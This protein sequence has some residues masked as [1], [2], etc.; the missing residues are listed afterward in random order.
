[1]S[2]ARVG[3]TQNAWRTLRLDMQNIQYTSW[4]NPP[5]RHA[6]PAV[7]LTR[8][9]P[10]GRTRALD[11]RDIQPCMQGQPALRTCI[12]AEVGHAVGRV[13]LTSEC[14]RIYTVVE[15]RRK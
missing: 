2:S 4:G 6:C 9:G 10:V 11:V 13:W 5:W 14:R 8:R 12:F 7:G 15:G 3:Q 1:M